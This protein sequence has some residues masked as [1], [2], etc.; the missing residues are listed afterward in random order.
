MKKA[1]KINLSGQIF[2]IDE[3]AYEKLKIY[4]DRISSHFSNVEETREIIADIEARIAELFREKFR[5]DSQV[6]TVADV[7]QVINIMGKPEDFAGE[8][9]EEAKKGP[10]G[11]RHYRRLYRDPDNAVIGGVAAGLSA[12]FNIDPVVLRIL[13]VVLILVGWGLPIII[14]LVLWIAVPKAETAAQKLEMR[15]EKVTVSNLEKK[16]REEYEDVKENL[17]KARRS[18]TGRKTED[19]FTQFFHIV[20][21]IFVAFLKVIAVIIALVFVVAGIS[22]IVSVIGFAFFGASLIPFGVIHGLDIDLNNTVLPFLNPT[23]ASV[24]V[25]AGALVILIPI[26]AIIYGL[27]KALF[28]FKAHDKSLGA[29]AFALWILAL[30]T[31]VA[32]IAYESGNF[33]KMEET[34]STYPLKTVTSDTLYVAVNPEMLSTFKSLKHVGVNNHWYIVRGDEFYGE[35]NIDVERSDDNVF[36]LRVVKSSRGSDE[37]SAEEMA[38]SIGYNYTVNDSL[39]TVDPYFRNASG[40]RYHSQSL[41]LTVFVPEGKAVS[42]NKNTADFLGHINNLD[43]VTSYR[44]AGKTWV[45]HQDGLESVR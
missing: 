14:Y 15:G 16:I 42:L 43:Q 33:S 31:T 29:S 27:F 12:Y 6:I 23:N 2:H 45:M 21:V 7:D 38:N 3:D 30:I 8:E 32:M 11:S 34:R 20:G 19:I 22:I 10:S 25:I 17:R 40:D 44:M 9:E 28:R 41:D 37:K 13:F 1:L 4:L 39:L 18:D 26:L 24:I 36:K 5:D 35:V